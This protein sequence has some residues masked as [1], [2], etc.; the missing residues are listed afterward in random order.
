MRLQNRIAIVTG[1]ASGIGLAIAKAYLPDGDHS[2]E[3]LM[4]WAPHLTVADS[5]SPTF[6]RKY[7]QVMSAL[8]SRCIG[9]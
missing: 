8:I 5:C 1:A 4:Y 3:R 6:Q 2:G 7:W 9:N